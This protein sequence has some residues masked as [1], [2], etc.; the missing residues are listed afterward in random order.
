MVITMMMLWLCAR[1]DAL[2]LGDRNY[3]N[4]LCE[5]QEERQENAE[6]ADE[7]GDFDPRW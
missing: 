1:Q 5:E 2:D 7:D 3:W 4:E 6:R